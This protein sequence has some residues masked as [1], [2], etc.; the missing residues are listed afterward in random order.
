MPA[1]TV[2]RN[3]TTSNPLI[4][5]PSL[6]ERVR[7][8]TDKRGIKTK[9]RRR[10]DGLFFLL[11]VFFFFCVCVLYKNVSQTN[12][13]LCVLSRPSLEW[14]P[15]ASLPVSLDAP[16]CAQSQLTHRQ[17]KRGK[18]DPSVSSTP[19]PPFLFSLLTGINFKFNCFSPA[20]FSKN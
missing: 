17:N 18:P 5:C 16:L 13:P 2:V 7:A 8:H 9:F 11:P 20:L 12:S 14:E 19:P 15:V 6:M 3:V 1:S 4:F 10:P